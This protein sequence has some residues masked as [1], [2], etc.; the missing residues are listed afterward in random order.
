MTF[1]SEE[2]DYST[3]T[4]GQAA[5]PDV[6][7]IQARWYAVQVASG[8]EKRVKANL[9]QRIQTLDVADRIVQVEIPQTPAIKVGKD[10]SR[11][12]SDEK[13]F[14]GYV[15]IRMYMDEDTWQVIKNTPNVINFVGAEQKR[16]YGRGRGHVKPLPL[17]HSEVERIFR[18]AQESEPV[19][20]VSM[21][22]G[23]HVVVLSGPFK[24][25]E[26]DVIE[27]SPERN[28][29][30]VLLSIFGRDTPVELEFNQVQKQN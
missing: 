1:A 13:I 7:E 15:L 30:K 9:D 21:A 3:E 5:S 6:P 10:G 29:L 22:T 18:N 24:D 12:Q 2:S 20:K 17:S 23:D 28:K 8:C 25:F 11:R 16:R 26:G 19:V 14:P 4:T 27:V